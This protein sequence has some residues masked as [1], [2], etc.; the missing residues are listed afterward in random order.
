MKQI[1]IIMLSIILSS[2]GVTS[3]VKQSLIPER[4][5]VNKL[6]KSFNIKFEN[7]EFETKDNLTLKGWWIKGN[8]DITIVLS[9]SFG[10]NRSGWEGE[11]AKGNHHKIDWLPS[12]KVLADYGYNIITFDHRACG[13]SEGELTYF[14]KKEAMDIVAAVKWVKNKNSD[15]KKFGIIGFSSGANATLRAINILENEED[16]LQLTGITVNLYWYEKMIKNSTIFFT[17]I[18]SF[19]VPAIKKSTTKIVGFNP[20]KEINPSNSLSKIK[21]PVLIVNSEFDEI[22]DISTIKD[23][24]NKRA[25]NTKL[26]ILKG[27]DRFY[28]YHFIENK[29]KTVINYINKNLN[30]KKMKH[31]NEQIAILNIEFQK[32]W[33][34]KGFFY[35]LL[36]KELTRK[37][38]INNTINLLNFARDNNIK[39]IQTPLIIDKNDVN[40]KKTPFPARIFKQLTKDTWKSEFTDG[41]Y[42]KTDIVVK[43]RCGFD[44]CEG[45]DLE[46]LLEQ[47]KIKTI[48]VSGFTT[49]HCVK[50]TMN[51]LLKQGYK[52]VLIS[53]C[54]AARNKKLQIKTEQ[55]FEVISSK[56]LIL[57]LKIQ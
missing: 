40:Y 27:E 13:E 21:A 5:E 9:H 38:V 54:T 37:G 30:K 29:P 39:I 16:E 3:K 19:M 46:Y 25:T 34:D 35:K 47:N 51:T 32:S 48:Y 2:C 11:D 10:A 14:G 1:T 31:N 20:E 17:N 44:A 43:G 22:A 55:Q 7:I 23:I 57:K 45:S 18:P 24:Y 28:A 52:C 53:D 49:D 50:E 42:K 36:K 4:Q 15:L 6:P 26:L 33:T 41:I 12:I 8:K 56:E